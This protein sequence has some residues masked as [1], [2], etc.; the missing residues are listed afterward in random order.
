MQNQPQPTMPTPT[1]QPFN[2]GWPQPGQQPPRSQHSFPFSL[3]DSMQPDRYRFQERL[4][5]LP[6]GDLDTV[7]PLTSLLN[8]LWRGGQLP[9]LALNLTTHLIHLALPF[10]HALLETLTDMDRFE[11]VSK[12]EEVAKAL[13]MVFGELPPHINGETWYTTR[14]LLTMPGRGANIILNQDY[15]DQ[16]NATT[17]AE[18]P[19]N[20]QIVCLRLASTIVHEL[21]HAAALA[22]C[23][24]E[25]PH[26]NAFIGDSKSDEIGFELEKYL[27]GGILDLDP[28]FEGS[29]IRDGERWYFAH[30]N[31]PSRINYR[32]LMFDWPNR[33]TVNNYMTIGAPCTCLATLP[34]GGISWTTSFLHISRLFQ[35]SYWNHAVPHLGR[36]ALHFPR[37]FGQLTSYDNTW[38]PR[39][40]LH[41]LMS[42]NSLYVVDP[43]LRVY[44]VQKI[45]DPSARTLREFWDRFPRNS[46]LEEW[47]AL[48]RMDFG[49]AE[50]DLRIAMERVVATMHDE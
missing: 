23:G 49:V 32:L 16:I 4:Y 48:A 1:T 42:G 35:K 30:N 13:D 47:N 36:A 24:R 12:L 22:N 50:P 3:R 40:L 2:Q 41:A 27:F 19:V 10:W 34:P 14:T 28:F 20:F 9:P 33:D 31:T 37:S 17:E 46:K 45:D 7:V 29:E 15:L 43:H 38:N 44:F 8:P 18:D 39:D 11:T 25:T 26:S 5:N 21:A 6:L